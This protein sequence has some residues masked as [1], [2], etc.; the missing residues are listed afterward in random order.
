[1]I[2]S[3]LGITIELNAVVAVLCRLLVPVPFTML[4]GA[5]T[6]SSLLDPA[7]QIMLDDCTSQKIYAIYADTASKCSS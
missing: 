3:E 2:G 4:D 1:M 5:G 6:S 7:K